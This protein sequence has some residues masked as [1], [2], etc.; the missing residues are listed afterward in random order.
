MAGLSA[1]AFLSLVS[2]IGPCFFL[3]LGLFLAGL[4]ILKVF[5]PQDC[6]DAKSL[7]RAYIVGYVLRFTAIVLMHHFSADGMFMPDERGYDGEGNYLA[8][9]LPYL[10]FKQLPGILGTTHVAYPVLIGLMYS[11]AGN[12]IL[13]AKLLNAFFGA[14]L[15]P[16]LYWLASELRTS[17]AALPRRAAW[18]AALFPFDIAW[19]AYLLRDVVLELFFTLL[20]A[21]SVSAI[22]RRSWGLVCLILPLAFLMD[23]LRFYAVLIWAGAATLGVIAWLAHRYGKTNRRSWWRWF[24]GITI[25]GVLLLTAVFPVLESR[26]PAIHFLA[27]S[28]RVL[29]ESG[30][31][32]KVLVFSASPVFI[33]T[34]FRAVLTYMFSPVPWIFWGGAVLTD[35]VLYPGMLLIYGLFPFFA[36]GLW[37]MLRSLDPAQVF[38]VAAFLLHAMIEIYVFQSGTRQRVMSDSVFLLCAAAGWSLRAKF[39]RGIPWAYAFVALVALSQTVVKVFS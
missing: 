11:F 17:D 25:G 12:A 31:D 21:C 32:T 26:F 24:L 3:H 33:I 39:P 35:Y 15:A 16:V 2:A 36:I 9:A 28:V 5:R 22:K 37:R 10:T 38:V 13:S 8:F 14:M 18:L 30:G 1:I 34:A 4:G 7:R 27:L 6:D 19:S 20:L 23:S 29:G